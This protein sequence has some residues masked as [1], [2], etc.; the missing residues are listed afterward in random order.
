MTLFGTDG[1][2]GL[3]NGSVLTAEIALSAAVAAA[4]LNVGATET[5][6][7]ALAGAESVGTLGAGK[8]GTVPKLICNKLFTVPAG[9]PVILPTA[10]NCF[11]PAST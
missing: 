5:F 9:K 4:Q 7:A 10:E 8:G 1:I 11:K 3:A 6:V 2:R